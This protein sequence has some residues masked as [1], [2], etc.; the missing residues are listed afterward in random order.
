MTTK[1]P[2]LKLHKATGQ[3]YVLLDGTRHYVGRFD[4][5]GTRQAADKLIAE[6]LANG[7]RLRVEP[8]DLTVMEL[9]N[10][11]RKHVDA[12]YLDAEGK[13]SKEAKHFATVIKPTREL[14]GDTPACK[15][16]PLAFKAVREKLMAPNRSRRYINKLGGKLKAMFKWAV[17]E[18]LV[19]A[20]V[21][22]A[23]RAVS[24]LER[25]RTTAKEN[26][27]VKPVPI[28]YVNAI[29]PFVSRQVQALIDLQLLT[30]A[31]QGEMVIMRPVDLDMTGDV[32]VYEP[33]EHKTKYRDHE[34][35]IYLGPKAQA[36]IRPFLDRPV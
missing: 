20:S 28:E 15:F 25:G 3:G 8:T 1:T 24:G 27:R 16:G 7:R 12:Y 21:Y 9:C 18:E 4:A 36:V 29:R 10:A 22:E 35:K 31:R 34:R 26:P 5:P 6:Y 19:P 23:L 11:F 2:S 14:Y 13:P 17:T 33:K 32:W 30:A